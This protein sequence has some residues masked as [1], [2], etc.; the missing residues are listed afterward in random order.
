MARYLVPVHRVDLQGDALAVSHCFRERFVPL[1]EIRRVRWRDRP[2]WEHAGRVLIETKAAGAAGRQIL[3][4]PR[5]EA[6]VEEL[7]ARIAEATGSRP[8]E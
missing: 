7:C 8:E 6:V 5:S 1:T 3:F 2:N 4:V